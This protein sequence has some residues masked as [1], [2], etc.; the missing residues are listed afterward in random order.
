MLRG[1][2]KRDAVGRRK[3]NRDVI[4]VWEKTKGRKACQEKGKHPKQW[5][6]PLFLADILNQNKKLYITWCHTL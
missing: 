1:K 4:G 5:F 2:I 3:T 6:S